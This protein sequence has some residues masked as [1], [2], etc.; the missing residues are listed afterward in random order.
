MIRRPPR[1]TRTDTLFPYTTLFRSPGDNRWSMTIFARDL[2][3][4]MAKWLYQMTQHDEWDYDGANEMILTDLEI[5]GQERQVLVDFD[6]NGFAYTLDR[7]TVELLVA[8]K[9]DPA[10]HWATEVDRETCSQQGASQYS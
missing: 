3:T 2:D 4:G 1:S 6:R 10:V 9:Y 7:V 5:D 8:E